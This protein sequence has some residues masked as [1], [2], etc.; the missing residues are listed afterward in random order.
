MDECHGTTRATCSPALPTMNNRSKQSHRTLL[1]TL[2]PPERS[3]FRAVDRN[4][5]RCT[6]AGLAASSNWVGGMCDAE[7]SKQEHRDYGLSHGW[8]PLEERLHDVILRRRAAAVL[9]TM[10]ATFGEKFTWRAIGNNMDN[11]H[12]QAALEGLCL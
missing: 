6:L 2:E 3:A 11:K 10:A 1:R 7:R 4:A 5:E 8:L 9:Y 12:D